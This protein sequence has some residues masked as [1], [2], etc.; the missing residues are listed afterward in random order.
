M[1]D[2]NFSNDGKES[3]ANEGFPL[4]STS[5]YVFFKLLKLIDARDT[6]LLI[7]NDNRV[8]ILLKSTEVNSVVFSIIIFSV[9]APASSSI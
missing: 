2:V 7:V 4:I 3:D 5:L 8:F 9:F 1:P 6:L